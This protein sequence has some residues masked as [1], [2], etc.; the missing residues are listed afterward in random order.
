ME[1]SLQD[2]ARKLLSD[3][4][5]LDA[6]QLSVEEVSPL[7][8]AA[9]ELYERLIALRYVAVEREVKG[10]DAPAAQNT[11]DE[12]PFRLTPV[13]PGQT[14]LIDAIEEVVKNTEPAEDPVVEESDAPAKEE[15]PASGR[16]ADNT[17]NEDKETR[18]P[19][20]DEPAPPV[21]AQTPKPEPSPKPAKQKAKPVGQPGASENTVAERLRRTPIEDLRKAI[22]LNQK[23]QFINDL[24]QGDSTRY[25]LLIDEVNSAPSLNDA[26]SLLQAANE[27]LAHPAEEDQLAQTLI[28]LVERRFL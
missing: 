23:F 18:P 1:Q 4:E 11:G 9:R 8:D 24:F 3:L 28:Q 13:L 25:N 27:R 19:K 16:E 2:L 6:G 5:R 15:T 14:S 20:K 21:V 17:P 26:R 7:T 10:S 12:M 22:G